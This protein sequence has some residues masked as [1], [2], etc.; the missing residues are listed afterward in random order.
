MFSPLSRS[1][2]R[3]TSPLRKREVRERLRSR[4]RQQRHLQ[5]ERF[6]ERIVLDST[7][8]TIA[9]AN[10]DVVQVDRFNTE[11]SVI[12][13][14]PLSI[15]DFRV[16]DG[17]NRGDYN[18]QIGGNA[19]DDT[20]QGILMTSIS[21]NG[22]DNSPFGD[23]IGIKYAT[24]HMA[25]SGGTYFI[26]VID[27]P[28]GAEHNTN[29]AAAWFP[30][31]DGWLGGYGANT[32]NGSKL[33]AFIGNENLS[34]GTHLIEVFSD[35]ENQTGPTG[36]YI[37][38]LREFDIYSTRQSTDPDAPGYDP[39]ADPNTGT[40]GDGVLL[41]TGAKNEDN[42]S[43]TQANA[44]GTWTVYNHDNGS[45][46]AAYESDPVS[47]VYIPR[48]DTTVVSG[49]FIGYDSTK[50]ADPLVKP[51]AS[52]SFNVVRT[53]RGTYELTI[54]GYTPADGVL[55][56]SPEGGVSGNTD[57]I[58]TYQATATSWIIQTRDITGMGTQ[59]FFEPVASF[60]FVPAAEDA[61]ATVAPTSGLITTETGGTATFDVVLNRQ[62]A[63]DVTISFASSD[64][65]EG[66]PATTSVTF[67]SL[68]WHTPQTVTVN[69]VSD[70]I[71]DGPQNYQIITTA[72]SIDP[73]FAGVAV[74]D[75]SLVNIDANTASVVVT[76]TDDLV[77]T[78]AGGTA[79][80]SV[81]LSQAPASDVII[82]LVSSDSTEG[83]PS[84]A[85][86]TFTVANWATPQV[87]TVTGANDAVDDG[88][89]AYS[90]I[91][92]VNPASDATFAVLAV[93]DVALTNLDDDTAGIL[94]TPIA[95]LT[96]TET[97]GAAAFT[98]T[99]TSEPT[100][101]VVVAVA[102]GDAT[103]GTTDVATLT[104]TPAD[105]ATPQTVTI[106]G[107]DDLDG[108]GDVAYSVTTSVTSGDAVFAA[109]TLPSAS[110]VNLDNEPQIALSSTVLRYGVLDP[111][112]GIDGVAVITDTDTELYSGGQLTIQLTAPG[113]PVDLVAGDRLTIRDDG[114]TEGK[115]GVT[116]TDVI[117]SGMVIGSFAGGEGT[118][119]LV[120]TLNAAATRQAVEALIRAVTFNNVSPYP[121]LVD[122]AVTVTLNDG[123]GGVSNAATRTIQFGEVRLA[124]FQQ[125]V[126]RGYGTYGNAG[127]IQ[128]THANPTTP[129]PAGGDANGLLVDWP[130]T[131]STQT[132]QV[133]VRFD[134]LF[135]NGP[136]QIPLGAQIVS[137][138][139]TVDTNNPG[140]GG[141]IHR[142]LVDW[143][144]EADTWGAFGS[145][146]E[147]RNAT[148]GVQTDG[149]E[150][151]ANYQ[152]QIGLVD[153]TGNT[154]TGATH[155]G[156]TSD[157]QAWA[158]GEQNFGWLMTGWP[159]R[160]DGWAFSPSEAANYL[161]RPL[162]TIEWV[163][164]ETGGAG[165]QYGVDGYTGTIDTMLDQRSEFPQDV[166]TFLYVDA[167]D[168]ANEAQVLLRFDNIIGGAA[169]QIPAG[170][171]VHSA[172]LTLASTG[173]NAMGD[174]GQFFRMA[175]DWSPF[176]ATWAS[177]GSGVQPNGVEAVASSNVQAGAAALDPNV[178]GAFNEFDVTKDVQSWV[179]NSTSNYGWALL[180][181]ANGTDDW[182]IISSEA[183]VESERPELRVFYTPAGVTV[184]PVE[185]L[186]TSEKGEA[187][188]FAVRLNTPPTHDVTFSISS[189]DTSEGTV[190]NSSLTFT[191]ANWNVPQ[192]VTVTG[193]DDADADGTV[194]YGVVVSNAT[195]A[196]AAYNGKFGSTL[197][198]RNFDD[199]SPTV[200][201]KPTGGLITTEAG[202]VAS[203]SVVL[204]FAPTSDVTI[205]LASDDTT[206]GTVLP[207]SLTFTTTNW[208]TPQIV[209]VTGVDDFVMDGD[210]A[211]HIVTTITGS[212]V[213]YQTVD[214]DDVAITN[215]DD[216]TANVTLVPIS[217]LQ[218]TES[219]GTATFS[220]VL[221]SQP[222]TGT[223]VR[224][225]FESSDLTEG[226]VTE[227]VE[228]T[229]AD[230][231]VP[232]VVTI[233]GAD[234]GLDDNNI[235]YRIITS[236]A[237]LPTSDPDYATVDPVDVSVTNV[238]NEN[239]AP[240]LTLPRGTTYYGIGTDG[241]AVDSHTSL[242][243]TDPSEYAGA[244][245]TYTLL[246]A[247]SDD[248]LTV[249]ND[250]VE[251]GQVGVTGS[252]VTYGGVVVG[253]FTG[254][255][256]TNPLSIT[257]NAS[258]T[259]A[260]AQAVAQVVT[261]SNVIADPDTTPRNIQVVATDGLGGTSEV[262]AKSIVLGPRQVS[263]FQEGVDWGYGSYTGAADIQLA[264]FA[265]DTPLPTG[266]DANGL[267]VDYAE[268]GLEEAAHVLLRFDN[269]IGNDLGQIPAGARII[270]AQLIVQSNNS[271]D[272]ARLHRMLTDWDA[273]TETWNSF[274][275]GVAPRN[276]EGGVQSDDLESRA[277]FDSQVGTVSANGATGNG[278]ISIGVTADIQAW[279]N[280][281]TNLGW[282]M[283]G[284]N[285]NADGWAFSASETA[286]S[287][288]RPLLLVD[289]VPG[290]VAGAG[291][292]QGVNDYTG[293]VDTRFVQ[294]AATTNY[295]SSTPIWSDAAN[296][297]NESQF[298]LRF[299]D[300]T[301][302][303]L[304]QI[305]AGSTIH[306]AVLT[307]AGV[308]ADAM[309][310]GGTFH[311][312]L[313]PWAATDTWNTWTN[314]IQAN[315][316]EAA[317]AYS[318]AAGNA[319]LN[320]DVQGGFTPF[321]VT[322]DVAAWV[323]GSTS[324]FGWAVL[325]WAGGTNG[326]GVASSESVVANYRPE[327]RVYYTPAPAVTVDP[328]KNLIASEGGSNEE[329]DI[330]LT[331][332]PTAE[333]TVTVTADAQAEV[334]V[335]GG[336]TWGASGA[337][338]FTAENGLL[339]QKIIVRAIDDA[340]I[341]GEH[342]S[343][344]TF[345][346]A[347][348]DG[349][350]NGAPVTNLSVAIVDNDM[351]LVEE[352]VVN[353]GDPQR[354]M[355]TEVNVRF[356]SIVAIGA[357]AFAIINRD[358]GT[359]I[360]TSFTTSEVGGKTVAT[361]RFLDGASVESRPIGNSLADGNYQLTI[362]AAQVSIN[363][364][365]LD[366]DGDGTA[367]GNHVYGD[368]D[369]DNFYR[370]YG[371]VDGDWEISLIDLYD[372]MVPSYGSLDGDE[373]YRSYLDADGDSEITL[374]DLYDYMVPSYGKIRD[375]SGF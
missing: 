363:G 128:L 206:E 75:V 233:T 195:S 205:S 172:V 224:V 299:D 156:V 186:V 334:S 348:T 248:R 237:T 375:T 104:F 163:P 303:G 210:R 84:V 179:R 290:D 256:G 239:V 284:W 238:D 154:E 167:A 332:L 19:T 98:V 143:D 2:R 269:L 294:N 165:F 194:T 342:A 202:D 124:Q 324:N 177:F 28:A 359:S 162:L 15:N 62:P 368:A 123:L 138:T 311:A 279:A 17:S 145:G 183:A 72:T 308:D 322:A 86:V 347:S 158:N 56:I 100:A 326:W 110:V 4:Q 61:G 216:D 139:L 209:E 236:I 35:P 53:A 235:G 306:A 373:T 85:S 276:A 89:I 49:K 226:T 268:P 66:V 283:I 120:V 270:S 198:V 147:G 130:E 353:D 298:L 122:R 367:G 134:S 277:T 108:D 25:P 105:W 83:T 313:Q 212:G 44:D 215:L 369:V 286:N 159:A 296:A 291:F 97:G 307:L 67:T 372:A 231:D 176:L 13:T 39:N 245:L 323:N 96:T 175:Q 193:Q 99:L 297:S 267:L 54:P 164:A 262:A 87:I 302:N 192:F 319:S 26:P 250:G 126:D 361:I 230:W 68:N 201:V 5:I 157:V 272:G 50:P 173:P 141:T 58:V 78:E 257:F 355:I 152:S 88:D 150:A 55:V 304:S 14:A 214:V 365:L 251:A 6:E 315:G 12:V 142:M 343:L 265:P 11:D 333:V 301:G 116:G 91:T 196:D 241:I 247:T 278:R 260:I 93:A 344:L 181:W 314:G 127:D 345:A 112:V 188:Q 191:A 362:D 354:S 121:T 182:G 263:G 351:L 107:V 330:A 197:N 366:G 48:S 282:A 90:I 317:I 146:L 95:G 125:N 336:T 113:A 220:A 364:M 325:P 305:P 271:G 350:Y 357:S 204:Y 218:T 60:I 327:L 73:D 184:A 129:Y 82:D 243:D 63:A 74:A 280:G 43:L 41:V 190:S 71:P 293:A 117:F 340:V 51:I 223:I 24:S 287:M 246:N 118:I 171:Y 38:D 33:V 312:M 109:I 253:A 65:T 358:S 3:K 295:A 103:E 32:T 45:N 46:G 227:Y 18:I 20:T 329:I 52:Q 111:A 149:V 199:D 252:S 346:V 135:G 221:D 225:A 119:P 155:I 1:N 185:N 169:S 328:I 207:A 217:G 254:G 9:A 106:T 34:L 102:S 320:P 339:A 292:Q 275:N 131:G 140:D 228:F 101:D 178:Q 337:L 160:T 229:D 64:P 57:N 266:G 92:S 94:L 161:E 70:G 47:F 281:E 261:F 232:R 77:T 219:G 133:L 36:R 170:A 259:P 249:R 30:Y 300:L 289:W 23:A 242:V 136:G 189:N 144:S 42:Y 356:N 8:H 244:T 27:S 21:Q 203:F 288:N 180:P 255:T 200:F 137:A 148:N 187:T 114:G 240:I 264:Q 76:P 10:L 79:A 321:D 338:V 7:L 222:A 69:G 371:D 258:A 208:A 341:E 273:N 274:A 285:G 213:D 370:L 374:L 211:F 309:G 234:D 80:F 349:D 166:S 22:R 316:I 81:V 59:D 40:A 331:T 352:V 29:V 115:I 310:D 360:A 335:D 16:R 31:A 174:G 151:V 168:D 37:V 318:V 132:T 153:G